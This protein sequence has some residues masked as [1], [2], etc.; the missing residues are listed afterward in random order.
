MNTVIPAVTVRQIFKKEVSVICAVLTLLGC[1][2]QPFSAYAQAITINK[3]DQKQVI[4]GFGAT[5]HQFTY[6]LWNYYSDD[7]QKKILDFLFKK[8]GGIGLNI[9]RVNVNSQQPGFYDDDDPRGR[10]PQNATH[11]ECAT[12]PNNWT[13]DPHQR[14]FAQSALARNPNMKFIGTP[15]SPPGWM[16]TNNDAEGNGTLKSELYDE[17]AQYLSDWVRRYN[18]D[19]IPIK[20]F[21][22]QNEPEWGGDSAVCLYNNTQMERLINTVADKFRADGISLKMLAPEAGRGERGKPY[23]DS[24]SSATMS[25][26]QIIAS[27]SYSDDSSG[28]TPELAYLASLGKP[29]WVTEKSWTRCSDNFDCGIWLAVEARDVLQMG[30]GAYSWWE[31]V[32]W[33]GNARALVNIRELPSDSGGTTLNFG[34]FTKR[35]YALGQFSRFVEA[36]FYRIGSSSSNSN[37]KQVAFKNPSTGKAIV[38]IVNDSSIAYTDRITGF[39]TSSVMARR[40]RTSNL[41]YLGNLER[42]TEIPQTPISNRTTADIYFPGKSITTMVEQ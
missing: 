5:A 32:G 40:I 2:L 12:C 36:G 19:G 15:W 13:R 3:N 10:D 27:H 6:A 34:D 35:A 17:Y 4:S 23:V 16:K 37:L 26:I 9:I 41:S 38:V 42:L 24:F 29:A 14:W 18:A 30:Y 8:D 39:S 20:Y 7:D 31:S 33:E 28:A 25:K 22:P 1:F 11:K 21:S